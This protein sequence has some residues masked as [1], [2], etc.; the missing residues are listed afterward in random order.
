MDLTE[1]MILSIQS[2]QEYSVNHLVMLSR[3]KHLAEPLR[4]RS[5][6]AWPD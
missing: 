2:P 5:G 6:Q 4:L 1:I 3:A